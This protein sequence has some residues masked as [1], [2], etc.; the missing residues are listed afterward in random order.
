M[1]VFVDGAHVVVHEAQTGRMTISAIQN[2]V[3]LLPFNSILKLRLGLD[4]G[5]W[6]SEVW[7]CGAWYEVIRRVRRGIR[8]SK[9][10]DR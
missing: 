4:E 2:I 5:E 6:E 3:G 10:L 8:D 1:R 9:S 7:C